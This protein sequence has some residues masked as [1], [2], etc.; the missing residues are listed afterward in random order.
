MEK[1]EN[2]LTY[3][4]LVNLM[5]KI[6]I[7]LDRS[8]ERQETIDNMTEELYEETKPM[9]VEKRKAEIEDA[10]KE[11]SEF[12]EMTKNALVNAKKQLLQIREK[13][14]KEYQDF[15]VKA[16]KKQSDIKT[17]LASIKKDFVDKDELDKIGTAEEKANNALEKVNN[18][19]KEFQDKHFELRK[20]LED[21]E[22]N[23]WDYAVEIEVE[24]EI[25]SVSLEDKTTQQDKVEPDKV[26]LNEADLD[27]AYVVK[28]ESV[29][30]GVVTPEP[31]KSGE[32]KSETIKPGVVT[33]EPVKSGEVKP[34]SVK[35]GVIRPE[36][37]KPGEVKPRP[38]DP[39][40]KKANTISKY[41][42]IRI[43]FNAKEQKY[44]LLT[45]KK[46]YSFNNKREFKLEDILVDNK[47]F[48][49]FCQEN[50][51]Y[52]SNPNMKS[53]DPVV[54]YIISKSGYENSGEILESY[55]NEMSKKEAKLDG[56]EISY[57]M[58]SIYSRKYTPELSSTIMDYANAHE[59]KG[60]ASVYKGRFAKFMEKNKIVRNIWEK[61]T[62]IGKKSEQKLLPVN[63]SD[64][65][66][67][68]KKIIDNQ[69]VND[70]NHSLAEENLKDAQRKLAE[71]KTPE[72]KETA[73]KEVQLA[74]DE[75]VKT[76]KGPEGLTAKGRQPM[77]KIDE[78]VEK[79]NIDH[80][81]AIANAEAK[82]SEAPT[83]L[84]EQTK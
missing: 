64:I 58:H 44:T 42:S 48:K 23:I 61:V 30:L 20:Q 14:E 49:K 31:V 80:G 18:E 63:V 26:E 74:R 37:I 22:K 71:A 75:F 6:K 50:Y 55:F 2:K 5:G 72:E 62:K 65:K 32:V 39:D 51:E 9:M 76:D 41:N 56:V 43:E 47:E 33:P 69:K 60:I 15:L 16:V 19:M 82:A 7:E 57:D 25:D 45:G 66:V 3:E 17:K 21:C 27:N 84:D 13:S 12:D 73:R 81:K 54:A 67:E 53:A 59:D 46:F 52:L 38:L 70:I 29:E 4:D 77:K 40:L 68:N 78:T 10:K 34:E 24:K 35:P 79:F 11:K 36:P 8:K 28:P 1:E 83:Q